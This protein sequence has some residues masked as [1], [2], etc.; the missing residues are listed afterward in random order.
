[1]SKETRTQANQT[2][3][4]DSKKKFNIIPRKKK[5]A[6]DLSDFGLK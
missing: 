6:K 2:N 4:S 5:K 1:M 3:F